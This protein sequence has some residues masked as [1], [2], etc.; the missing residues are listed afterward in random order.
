MQDLTKNEEMIL[1]S[2]WKLKDNAYGITIRDNIR[3]LTGRNL[4]YGSMYNTLC[5]LLRKGLIKSGE[6][7]PL[8]KKGGRRKILYVLTKEGQK[9]LEQA[10]RIQKRVWGN[11]PDF[12]FGK[13]Q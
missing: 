10:Q 11:I 7:P 13:K 9:A 5:Q 3:H 1:L 4:N 2:I 6:S 8:A 12:D